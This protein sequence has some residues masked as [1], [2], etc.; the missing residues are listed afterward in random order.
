LTPRVRGLLGGLGAALALALGLALGPGCASPT[1][2]S[3]V[4]AAG[5]WFA[6][7]SPLVRG[8]GQGS[9]DYLSLFEPG[10]P[11]TSA[12]THVKV[13]KIYQGFVARASDDQLRSV[14]DDL[15]RRQI[16]VALEQGVL[17]TSEGCGIGVEGFVPLQDA[18]QTV[19]RIQQL[20]GNLQYIA[21]D[22]PFFYG[23]I[24]DGPHACRW[25]VTQVAMSAANTLHALRAVIPSV[26]VGDIEP[27]SAN[28]RARG[29]DYGAWLD[30]YRLATGTELAFLHFD[31]NWQS[32]AWPGDTLEFRQH[33]EERHIPYG[34][35]YNGIGDEASDADWTGD[36]EANMVK[37]EVTLQRIPDH[38]VFQSWHPYPIHLLP[39]T[40]PGTFTHLID[41]YF[42][43]RTSLTLDASS[44]GAG[45]LVGA[46]GAPLA[47]AAVAVSIKPTTGAG[48]EAEYSVSGIVPSDAS[49][50]LV[51]FRLNTECACQGASDFLLYQVLYAEGGAPN[52]VPNS[53]FSMALAGWNYSGTGALVVVP[54][55]RGTGQALH[56]T[57][58]PTDSLSLNSSAIS[59]N[60]G[61]TYR[62]TFV[63]KVS[64]SS[65]GSGYFMV[66]FYGPPA[67]RNQSP[68]EILRRTILLEA[69]RKSMG[70]VSTDGTGSYSL[71]LSYPTS[72]GFL[73]EASYAGSDRY[74]P[75]YASVATPPR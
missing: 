5:V 54:S 47:G 68:V 39:E 73:V 13:F 32:P 45:R 36:A 50:A 71:D 40:L 22:E 55:D 65:D 42:R 9:I 51:A 41:R 37:Y 33:L 6:P 46:S 70:A 60:A 63:A 48:I 11:W 1:P 8:D 38:A 21:M 58:S 59:A 4:A 43:E 61:V 14:F 24:F 19:M 30:A 52:Q 27:V 44:K 57:A 20:G 31:V 62:V 18:V 2:K 3:A 28:L 69:G 26:I 29:S 72:D 49:S 66:A 56:V 16:A 10:A 34:V 74:W 7:L 23:S 25:S 53:S 64:P 17:D 12:A 35:I 15:K 75:S 67:R